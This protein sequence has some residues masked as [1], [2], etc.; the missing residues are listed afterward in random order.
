MIPAD[1]FTDTDYFQLLAERNRSALNVYV[2]IGV[3]QIV[4]VNE[5]QR[6]LSLKL[7]T[8]ICWEDCRVAWQY[9]QHPLTQLFLSPTLFN[10]LRLFVPYLTILEDLNPAASLSDEYDAVVLSGFVCLRKALPATLSCN[11]DVKMYPLDTQLCH[12]T[13]VAMQDKSAVALHPYESLLNHST[14]AQVSTLS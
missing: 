7:Q 2:D 4:E 5:K 13:F 9:K 11:I 8:D 1:N 6:S 14:L 10:E 3:Y 12:I